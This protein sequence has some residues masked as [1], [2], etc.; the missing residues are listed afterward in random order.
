MEMSPDQITIA[1]TVYNRRDFVEQAIQSALNQT[2][3]VRVVVV[4][5]C[6]PDPNL[7]RF[8]QARFGSRIHYYR[9]ERRRGLFDNWNA[10]MELCRTPWLSIL[11]DDDFLDPGFIATMLELSTAAPGRG[12]YFGQVTGIDQD[13]GRLPAP[14]FPSRD[15]WCDVDLVSFADKNVVSFPGQL[16]RVEHART[17]G[18]FRPT[19]LFAGDWEMWF[20]LSAFFGGARTARHVGF[21]RVQ[22][23]TEQGTRQ[24]E[25]SGKKFVLD[26]VQRKRNF[27]VLKE[28][29]YSATFE[30]QPA[31][32][33]QIPLKY[34]MDNAAGFSTRILAYNVELF[35]QARPTSWRHRLFQVAM[36]WFGVRFV[37]VLSQFWKRLR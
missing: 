22:S 2:V 1:I 5:D 21:V 27:R 20:R 23:G 10:C 13:G 25:R 24:V 31:N 11:H 4:E 35:V 19:S 28:M 6:G 12:L 9:N 8:I 34:L 15:S 30:R 36:R 14:P 26:N 18:G 3:P 7:Q 33:Y 32:W 29:G 37:R 16:F 17:L